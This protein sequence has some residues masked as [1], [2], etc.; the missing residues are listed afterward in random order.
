[1][2]DG[3]F[4]AGRDVEGGQERVECPLPALIT[5]QKGLNE[6][7]YAALKG[8]MAAKRK[9]VDTIA[10]ADLGVEEDAD[11]FYAVRSLELPPPKSEGTIIQGEDDPA[12]AAAKLVNLLRSEAKAI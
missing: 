8:I 4:T 1:M 9:P 10:V 2:G 7:R 12:G 3:S 11:P 6:P 5:C